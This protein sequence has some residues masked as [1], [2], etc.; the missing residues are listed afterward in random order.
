M[1]KTFLMLILLFTINLVLAEE[2]TIFEL[3]GNVKF[4]VEKDNFKKVELPYITTEDIKVKL[5]NNSFFEMMLE[6]GTIIK[7]EKEGTYNLSEIVNIELAKNEK[8]E[9]NWMNDIMK[10]NITNNGENF[11]VA[12]AGTKASRVENIINNLLIWDNKEEINSYAANDYIY[13]IRILFKNNKFDEVVSLVNNNMT[14]F[15]SNDD[16][17]EAL[18][19]LGAAFYKLNMNKEKVETFNKLTN[20]FPNSKWVKITKLFN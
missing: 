7:F 16:K 4:E 18:Y 12:T 19:L 9:N 20:E 5:G 14:K 2:H 13:A 6:D 8:T 17:A 1:K 15:N 3:N 10:T 11:S